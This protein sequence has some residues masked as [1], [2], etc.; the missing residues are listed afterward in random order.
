MYKRLLSLILLA[1]LAAT[2]VV[3][4]SFP[5]V[6]IGAANTATELAVKARKAVLICPGPVYVNGG[7]SG[8]K[9]GKFTQSGT[10]NIQ[11]IDGAKA[12]A[13]SA[14]GITTISGTSAE[15]KSFNAIQSQLAAQKF[16]GGLAAANCLPGFNDAWLVAGDNSVGREALLVL[17]NPTKVDATVSLEIVGT[18]GP[19]QGTGLSGIS[20]PAGKVTVLPL[21]AFAPKAVTFAVHVSSRGAML[22]MWIQQKTIRGLTPG[23]LDYVGPSASAGKTLEIPG[24]FIRNSAKLTKMSAADKDF[25]DTKP[26]LRVLAPG[27]SEATFTAQVQG[28]DGTSFG[29]V[30][31][32][33]VAAGSVADFDL[34]ELADGDYIV[35]IESDQPILAAANFN[36]IGSKQ[37]DLAWASAVAPTKLDSGFTTTSGAISKL[38]VA[39]PSENPGTVSLNGRSL[40]IPA[41][42]NIVIPLTAGTTYRITSSIPVAASQVIDMSSQVA[43]VPVLDFR[44]V[45]GSVKVQIR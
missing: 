1:G 34:G 15:S 36:R 37:P 14:T 8:L 35:H 33:T 17:V 10:A 11:G 16:A 2:S 45:A 22:G 30:I 5:K 26:I 41:N 9:L 40:S 21:A 42:S 3:F 19:I 24:L 23:G 28:A 25:I 12:I 29:T 18:D 32:G 4:I 43:V 31:Q 7:D 38:S 44:L 27:A 20:A 13:I 39:N 6:S